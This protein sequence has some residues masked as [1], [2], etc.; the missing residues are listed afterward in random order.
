[1]TELEELE[2]ESGMPYVT[3]VERIAMGR[4]RQ[5]GLQEGLQAGRQEG[6]QAGRQEG[7]QAGRQE[8]LQAGR[9]EGLASL[10]ST[11]LACRFGQVP[12]WAAQK[13]KAAAP[14]ALER[15]GRR[16][17]EARSLEDVFA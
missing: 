11:Q 16:I 13:L 1:M 6:L 12:E 10:L 2:A 7:L 14:E 5:E 17:F 15:W 8:G 3:S 9:R 4:G